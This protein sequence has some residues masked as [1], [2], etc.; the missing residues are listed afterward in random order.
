MIYIITCDW[1]D[2]GFFDEVH[3]IYSSLSDAQSVFNELKESDDKQAD[4]LR[5]S[6]TSF[7]A[8]IRNGANSDVI[9]EYEWSVPE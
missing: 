2:S 3:S 4:V 9:E 8:D 6:S 7:G 1:Y 5:L